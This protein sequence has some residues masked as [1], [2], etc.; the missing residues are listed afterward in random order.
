MNSQGWKPCETRKRLPCRNG[1]RAGAS[2]GWS[3]VMNNETAFE[4]AERL[5]RELA[6]ERE[7]RR[8]ERAELERMRR[9]QPEPVR[10]P[11]TDRSLGVW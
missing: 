11:I 5:E 4:R 3:S 2:A 8:R 9:E 6:A 1:G 7:Q 10:M